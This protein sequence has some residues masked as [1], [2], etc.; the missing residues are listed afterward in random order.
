MDPARARSPYLSPTESPRDATP[1]L[2]RRPELTRRDVL[3]A[4]TAL[5][6]LGG[7]AGSDAANSRA[8]LVWGTH[9]SLAPTWLEPAETGGVITPFMML[10]AIHDALVKP[11]PNDPEQLC[12]AE[13]YAASEDGLAHEF[14]LRAN[15]TFHNG[16]PVTAEDVKFSFQRY[17]GNAARF[18]SSKVA[19]V[20]TPDP[21]RVVFRLNAPWADFLTYYCGVTGAGWVVPKKYVESVGDEGFKRAP[22]GAGPYRFVSFSPGIEL[23]LEAFREY[24]RHAPS[25]RNLIF[26]VIPD[27]TTRLAALKRGEVDIAYSIRGELAEEIRRTPGLELKAIALNGAQWLYFPDQWDP[28]SPWHDVRVRQAARLALNRDEIN[29]AL[30]LGYSE[31]TDTI[32]PKSFK[33]YWEPPKVPYNPAE[34]RVLLAEAGY[35]NGFDAGDYYCDASYSNLAEASLNYLGEVGIRAKLRPIERAAF[36]KGYAEKKYRNIVQGGSGAFGNAATRLESFV[37]KGGSYAYG[38]YPDIDELFDRQ[39]AETDAAKRETIL[40]RI[41]QLMHEHAIYAP[42]WQLGFL[43]GQGPRVEESGLGLIAGYPYSAPYEDVRL[44]AGA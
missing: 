27:E 13:S 28:R 43:S 18:L 35:T 34:A 41:Q 23:V 1:E 40:H 6:L 37:V 10:Y 17:R 22:I 12:L 44:K 15:A 30:T 16:A 39:V 33:F 8:R 42:I 7:S 5:G 20:E 24:W 32:V 4:A 31:I 14:V 9:I 38:S 3:A 25:V 36:L 19:A 21:R 29:H 26:R 2:I 11:M